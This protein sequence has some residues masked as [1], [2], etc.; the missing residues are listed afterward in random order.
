MNFLFFNQYRHEVCKFK[1]GGGKTTTT[2]TSKPYQ[3]GNYDKLLG[4]ADQ[5]MADGGFD[6]NFGGSADYNPVA[7]QTAGQTAGIGGLNQTGQQLE[8][9][10]NGQGMDS[11]AAYLGPYDPSKTGLNSAIAASNEQMNWDF[12]TQVRPELRQGA[13]ASGQY[14]SS[15][16]GV[17]EGIATARLN[18]NQANAANTMAFQDQ[19]AYNTNR[20]SALQ[21]MTSIA[22]GLGSGS[23]MQY[24]AGT[25]QQA[26][27]QAQKNGELQKWAYENNASLND[28]LAYQQLISGDMGGTNM[29]TTK[30]GQSSGGGGGAAIGSIAGGIAGSFFGPMGTMAGSYLGG[31]VGGAM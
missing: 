14:G 1:G 8:G 10:L 18:Q 30:G 21:N 12:D 11:L 22:K 16:A 23:G 7:G 13:V 20:M 3:Q 9:L 5:W 19:Q 17:A 4:G 29:Q 26:Q 31:A 24:D 2:S 27:D 28:L 6:K 15:R 25:L